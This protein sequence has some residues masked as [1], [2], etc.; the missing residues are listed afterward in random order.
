MFA[1]AYECMLKTEKGHLS[2]VLEIFTQTAI[3]VCEGQQMDMNFEE[4]TD[5]TI[6][7]YI[8]MIRL[9][10][11]VLLAASLK[12]GAVVGGASNENARNCYQFGEKLG[13][14][15]QLMDDL[16][17]LY[18]DESKFGKKCGGDIVE[19]KKTFLYL[20]AKEIAKEEML[21]PLQKY[22]SDSTP[23]PE[24]KVKEVKKIYDSLQI[25]ELTNQE[26]DKYYHL[27]MDNLDK[28]DIPEKMKE[29]LKAYTLS[30]SKRDK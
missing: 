30:L 9:K 15:F 23:D 29:N 20:K 2:E 8:E 24:Y 11:A 25:K 21:S 17:D 19:N 1:M 7:E 4:R 22:Y 6:S 26:I 14:S 10:T 16:L 27:A 12:I 5:V 3:E 13:L 28:I 18:G